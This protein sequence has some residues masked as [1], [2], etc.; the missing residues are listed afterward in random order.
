MLATQIIE[1]SRGKEAD[2]TVS[3]PSLTL[4]Q[5]AYLML[6]TQIISGHH[7][8]GGRLSARRVVEETQLGATPV[9]EALVRL[10]H[11]GLLRPLPRS[12]YVVAALTRQ[13]VIDFHEIWRL[14]GP[15]IVRLGVENRTAEQLQRLEEIAGA[16]IA[17]LPRLTEEHNAVAWLQ[18]AEARFALLAEASANPHLIALNARLSLEKERIYSFHLRNRV[19]REGCQFFGTDRERVLRSLDYA[20]RRLGHDAELATRT[21]IDRTHR[22]MLEV[23][24][25]DDAAVAPIVR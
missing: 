6:R 24:E 19:G 15:A 11:E 2:P 18:L 10:Q 5:Q 20:R 13:T 23:F 3:D 25:R 4:A 21:A 8:P 17:L 7:A 9:R 1:P 12:G 16:V 14:V 22:S